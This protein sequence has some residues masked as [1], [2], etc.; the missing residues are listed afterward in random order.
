VSAQRLAVS[1]TAGRTGVVGGRETHGTIGS[2]RDPGP[3][4]GE[5]NVAK[6]TAACA[7]GAPLPPRR[8]GRP[9]IR[10]EAC[11]ADKSAL[12]KAWR[13]S[14]PSEVAAYQ[15]ARLLPWPMGRH[16]KYLS[17]SQRRS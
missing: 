2:V 6:E 14:H 16:S 8:L 15:A 12:A 7:C 1:I 4:C 5:K 17:D 13:A 3:A 11:T 10:C 9:R